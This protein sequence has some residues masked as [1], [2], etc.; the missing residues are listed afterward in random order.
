MLAALSGA[1]TGIPVAPGPPVERTIAA[2]EVHVYTIRADPGRTLLIRVE[3]MGTDVDVTLRQD[4][5]S[6]AV[7][8]DSPH[9][10]WGPETLLFVDRPGAEPR[11]EVRTL[12]GALPGRYSLRLEELPGDTPAGRQR[13]AAESAVTAAL[14]LYA[15]GTHPGRLDAMARLREAL[16]L[17]SALGRREDEAWTLDALGFLLQD[18]GDHRQA[19]EIFARSL[20]LWQ[21]LGRTRA[22]A[23]VHNARA[24]GLSALG[25]SERALAE[26]AQAADL[27]KQVG[28]ERGRA[29]TLNNTGLVHHRRGDPRAALPFYEE[30]LQTFRR[31]GDVRMTAL[32]TG[33]LGGVFDE[34]GEPAEARERY[35]ASLASYQELGDRAGEAR[36]LGNLAGLD[37]GAGNL[38]AA[39]D[40]YTRALTLWRELG[41]RTG[42]ALTLGNLGEAYQMLGEPRR[43]RELLE[44]SLELRRQVGD[45]RGEAITL[46]NLGLLLSDD[47]GDLKGG[48]VRFEEALAQARTVG[49][50]RN[51]VGTLLAVGRLQARLGRRE[52]ALRQLQAAGELSHELGDRRREAGALLQIGVI[53]NANGEP[54]EALE[55][56]S[57]ALDLI[58]E[59]ED[60]SREP[61]VLGEIARA[62]RALGRETDALR[63]AEAALAGL[64]SLRAG[65]SSPD[66][67]AAY[68]APRRD[69]YELAVELQMELHRRDP[70]GGHD[71]A[72]LEIAERARARGLLD[73]LGEAGREIR[74]GIDPVLRE[75]RQRL[76]DRLDAK[77]ALRTDR[78]A[79]PGAAAQVAGLDREIGEILGELDTL[80]AEIR[81]S[82]PGYAALTRPEPLRAAGIQSLLDPETTLLVYFLGEARSF[83]WA[84]RSDAL[85]VFELPPRAEIDAAARTLVEGWQVQSPDNTGDRKAGAALSRLVLGPLSGRWSGLR[86]A[87]V[88]DGALQH[89]PFAALPFPDRPGEPL[90][91]RFEV[92]HL[93]SASVLGEQRRRLAGRPAASGAVAV[94]ADP[95]FDARDPRVLQAR[96]S[97]G[98]DTTPP[99]QAAGSRSDT[100]DDL[101]R[102][103]WTRQEAEA[104]AG[105]AGP[106]RT[107][108]ALDFEANLDLVRTGALH[109]Y[110]A[111]H[112]ATHGVLSPERPELSGLVLSRVDA[113]GMPRPGVLRLPDI[114]NLDLQ[115]DVAVLSG[116]ETA[117]GREIRGEGIVGLAR[118][119]LYAG[120]GKVVASLWRVRDRSTAD[121]MRHFYQ[122]LL[123]EGRPPAAALREAQLALRADRRWADPY[124][125][126]PFAVYGDWR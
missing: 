18:E 64:E 102:L 107:L 111:L 78:S 70:A 41:D 53:R 6:E 105:L 43:A 97:H 13:I 84:V 91:T 120:A 35:S 112:F 85:Q 14:R 126:A 38:Q 46:H 39:L 69:L 34:L 82:S 113:A 33:N 2:G 15:A 32:V 90:I 103:T 11:I 22:Q 65:V 114:Y 86:L 45:R 40:R 29:V 108:L 21:D 62:E 101:P 5:G 44:R 95:V 54:R 48:L 121:L 94:L 60:R 83:L 96:G 77:A 7:R 23:K 117:L 68:L 89:V 61:T 37:R 9:G 73:L 74:R 19:L 57:R 49:D 20:A 42:E 71:R 98:S 17:W 1:A 124:Y 16:P 36:V 51:E 79:R 52:E 122:A 110:R 106:G 104:I 72:A 88:P 27:W 109:G 8:V 30:A 50:R 56:L 75:R 100:G 31:I 47:L 24:F 116:C 125:W 76:L 58:R 118:G 80:D 25:E 87:V 115:A 59:I 3:Q 28:D 10:V 66:L 119:F 55:V 67:R 93:P 12:P 99:P 26:Y 92:V 81:R 4:A 63:D 123:S